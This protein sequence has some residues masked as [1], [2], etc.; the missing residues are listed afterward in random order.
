MHLGDL[1]RGCS[2]LE[3]TWLLYCTGAATE[4]GKLATVK[5]DISAGMEERG[6][7]GREKYA[8]GYCTPKSRYRPT[9]K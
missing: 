7:G 3:M 5:M 8:H 2:D 9:C 1:A 4:C 6:K